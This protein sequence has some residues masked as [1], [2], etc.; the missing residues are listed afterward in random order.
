MQRVPRSRKSSPSPVNQPV[1]AGLR[2]CGKGPPLKV[3]LTERQKCATGNRKWAGRCG[4]PNGGAR[5]RGTRG[6]AGTD[7]GG[8]DRPFRI[9]SFVMPH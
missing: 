9:R 2:V 6:A 8:S 5:R 1:T 7:G 3:Y 4:E